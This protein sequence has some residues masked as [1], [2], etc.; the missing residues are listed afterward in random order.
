MVDFRGK[1]NKIDNESSH[2]QIRD[3]LT[4][5]G[6][7]VFAA[8]LITAF[9][10]FKFGPSGRYE[11]ATVLLAPHLLHE[12]NYNDSNPKT[13]GFDRFVFDKISFSYLSLSDKKWRKMDI[14]EAEYNT[15]YQLIKNDQ[16]ILNPPEEISADFMRDPKA[17]LSI[18]VRTESPAAWQA[19]EKIFQ[20]VQFSTNDNY[21]RIALHEQNPGVD[22]VYFYHPG[23]VTQAYN[24][25]VK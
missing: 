6:S 22:W 13:G 9:F 2:K 17:S 3:L 12:L 8:F 5:I 14:T 7:G 4:V 15:F 23:I 1:V 18:L 20:E 11:I 10:I 25:F 21:Y 19:V 16:S 24:Q